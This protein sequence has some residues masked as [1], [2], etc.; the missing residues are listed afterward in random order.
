MFESYEIECYGRKYVGNVSLR[1]F[2]KFT[3]KGD[4]CLFIVETMAVHGIS[5]L[6]SRIIDRVSS[7]FGGLV[8]GEMVK[9]LRKFDLVVEEN[10]DTGEKAPAVGDD[11]AG[12][13]GQEG[14]LGVSGIALLV[15]QECN[16]SCVY[17]YGQD[18]EYAGKGMMS[19][20]TAF[21]A[22]DWLIENSKGID[23][24]NISFFGG[25]PLLNFPLIRKTVEYA[26]VKVS[27]KNKK[28]TFSLTTNGS[29]LTDEIIS[30]LREEKIVPMVSFDGPPAL[31]NRQRPFK[32]GSGSYD[33][34]RENI[35]KLQAVLPDVV[36]R[37]TVCDD[38]DP[39][40]CREGIERLGV[41]RYYVFKASP[42]V[43]A[44]EEER[45]TH[46]SADE[47]ISNRMISFQEKEWDE[48][49][50]SVKNRKIE[51]ND[52]SERFFPLI[53]GKKRYFSCGVGKGLV[54]ISAAGDIYPCHRFVGLEDVKFG[55]IDDY[56]AEGIND[57]HRG[58][59]NNVPQCSV[60]WTRYLCGGG[61]LYDNRAHTGD[62]HRPDVLFCK[63]TKSAMETAIHICAQLEV[64][65]REY[66]KKMAAEQM[67]NGSLP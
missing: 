19:E 14:Y 26:K 25:E 12:A 63:E 55:N 10:S 60:C 9:E 40:E 29:L 34:V 39:A 33:A 13:D 27:E 8:P 53:M 52:A 56:K 31:Q 2:H 64:D 67:A 43:L 22:V 4:I 57:Y 48:F 6:A 49:F 38:A 11:D 42:V 17:C 51:I 18:G 65:D 20:E 7:S 15:A 36:A 59:V 5:E 62:M 23:R 24:V 35:R 3:R 50:A 58:V 37:G 41:K 44:G 46:C 30:F 1:E 16:M 47:S 66:V 61:C 28:V 54:G 45:D 21:R 32:N